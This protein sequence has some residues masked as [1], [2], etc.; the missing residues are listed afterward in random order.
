MTKEEILLKL[1][2]LHDSS[3]K[4]SHYE[5]MSK[6]KILDE[7]K[8][9]V[10]NKW[11]NDELDHIKKIQSEIKDPLK[12]MFYD[13]V[14]NKYLINVSTFSTDYN[15]TM[16]IHITGVHFKHKGSP[17][18]KHDMVYGVNGEFSFCKFDKSGNIIETSY[19]KEIDEF[20]E[21]GPY[22]TTNN[23]YNMIP[24]G[25]NGWKEISKEQYEK[26]IKDYRPNIDFDYDKLTNKNLPVILKI[27]GNKEY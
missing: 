13:D 15:Y 2:E 25:L 16:F 17:Y 7:D 12:K 22:L 6:D 18:F 23:F 8:K 9:N 14:Y 26:I 24:E 19:Y 1:K 10:I 3:I 4:C 27:P 21:V 11:I 5:T 20:D